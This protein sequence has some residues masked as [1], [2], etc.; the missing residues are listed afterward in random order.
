MPVHYYSLSNGKTVLK[1]IHRKEVPGEAHEKKVPAE[2]ND[3]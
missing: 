1:I 3:H 2:D